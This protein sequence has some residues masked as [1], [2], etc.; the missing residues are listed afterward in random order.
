M[1]QQINLY[2]PMLRPQK[3][4]FSAVSMFALTGFFVVVFAGIYGYSLNYLNSIENK[5]DS[6]D[7]NTGILRLQIEKL[8]KQYPTIGKSKLLETEIARVSRELEAR[9]E[10]MTALG[11]YDFENKRTFFDFDYTEKQVFIL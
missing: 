8:N 4:P 11:Q 7:K 3:K 2:Q 1:K 10:I 9:Q 6:I 5:L